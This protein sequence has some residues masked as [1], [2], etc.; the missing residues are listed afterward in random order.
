MNSG[1]PA[2]ILFL[3]LILTLPTVTHTLTATP[4]GSSPRS[5]TKETD[6]LLRP[7][8]IELP[9]ASATA[10]GSVWSNLTDPYDTP[11]PLSAASAAYDPTSQQ[12]LLFGGGLISGNGSSSTLSNATWLLSPSGHW[13]ELHPSVSPSPRAGASLVY[14]PPPANSF[15]L[16]AGANLT[17]PLF[18]TWAFNLTADTWSQVSTPIHPAGRLFADAASLPGQDGFYLYGGA[19]A[20]GNVAKII[21]KVYYSD[22]W[23]YSPSVGW[24]NVTP[25]LSPPGRVGAMMAYSGSSSSFVMSGGIGVVNTQTTPFYDTWLFSTVNGTW[26]EVTNKTLGVATFPTP[27]PALGCGYYNPINNKVDYVG[28]SGLLGTSNST[29]QWDPTTGWQSI[30]S[31]N[32]P[33]LP[34]TG[35]G[36]AFDGALNGAILFGGL[37]LNVFG[38]PRFTSEDSTTQVR[39]VDWGLSID[40]SSPLVAATPFNLSVDLAGGKGPAGNLSLNL[41]LSDSSGTLTPGSVAMKNGTGNSTVVVWRPDPADVIQACQWGLCVNLTVDVRAPP[42]S[43]AVTLPASVVAGS[44][45]NV[46]LAVVDAMGVPTPWWNGTASVVTVPGSETYNAS[47][48]DG[49]AKLVLNPTRSG[50]YTLLAGA[51]GL[52]GGSGTFRVLPGPLAS[53][54]LHLSANPVDPNAQV[55]LGIATAD[56][57]GNPVSVT[58]LNLS[59]SLGDISP[60]TLAVPA[61]GILNV[62]LQIGNRSGNDTISVSSGSTHGTAILTVASL[63]VPPPKKTSSGSGAVP[64]WEIELLVAVT[65][66]V[67]AVVGLLFYRRRKGQKLRE[68]EKKDH[69]PSPPAPA[70]LGFLPFKEEQNE[71]EK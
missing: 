13:Q 19:N 23:Y 26:S 61:T 63:P 8:G 30:A 20:T 49:T 32:T 56:Q 37:N 42:E 5:L 53:I 7:L 6:G 11:P 36:C 65:V 3:V 39:F 24:K 35:T 68:R 43:L 44:P 57:F 14:L 69:P 1:A 4:S 40:T 38:N 60:K 18:D 67:L 54:L 62:T 48:V 9:H 31:A 28:G 64:A 71:D 55:T 66:A 10:I 25:A 46:T 15:V 52:V 22:T 70:Y 17:Q 2:A 21:S 41:T 12:M 58:S 50:N 45:L 59:D 33:P 34:M 16:F 29:W 27:T 47:V 51:P